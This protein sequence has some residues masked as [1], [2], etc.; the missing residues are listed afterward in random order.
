MDEFMEL[1]QGGIYFV[2]PADIRDS[3]ALLIRSKQFIPQRPGKF[4]PKDT[5]DTELTVFATQAE[6]DAGTP[7]AHHPT[8]YWDKTLLV[9]DI[10][11]SLGKSIIVTLDQLP[12]RDGNHPAWVFRNAEGEVRQKVIAYAKK[13]AEEREAALESMPSW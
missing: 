1:E 9:R 10:Q 11:K 5:G 7:T 12:A 8:A 13:K 2:K 6:L 3:V 4:G